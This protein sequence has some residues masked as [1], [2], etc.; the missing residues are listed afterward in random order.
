MKLSRKE[1]GRLGEDLVKRYLS[2]KDFHAEKG[3]GS[4]PDLMVFLTKPSNNRSRLSNYYT[5]EVKTTANKEYVHR[6]SERQKS[7]ND[8]YVLVKIRENLFN[9]IKFKIQFRE[10]ADD[11]PNVFKEKL[12]FNEWETVEYDK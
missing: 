7:K 6:P 3:Y 2:L 10:L 11:L 4:I 1:L 5:C 8:I 9:E 12:P